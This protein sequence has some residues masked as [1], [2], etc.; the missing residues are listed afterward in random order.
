MTAIQFSVLTTL[1]VLLIFMVWAGFRAQRNDAKNTEE[2]R[3]RLAKTLMSQADSRRA[4]HLETMKVLKGDSYSGQFG[5]L[6]IHTSKDIP[7]DTVALTKK[8]TGYAWPPD[9]RSLGAW[10]H[11]ED[12]HGKARS[13]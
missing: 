12:W 3:N 2:F 13:D 1:L 5:G 9:F 11:I 10:A 7:T 6:D 8:D 4:N